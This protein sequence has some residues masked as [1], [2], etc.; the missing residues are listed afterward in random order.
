MRE[1]QMIKNFNEI[2]ITVKLTERN[3]N[4]FVEELSNNQ[5]VYGMLFNTIEEATAKFDSIC[6]EYSEFTK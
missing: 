6:S 2:G 3:N 1:K 5:P 4:H